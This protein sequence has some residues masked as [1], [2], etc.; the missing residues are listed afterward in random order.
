MKT[1]RKM[2]Q[3]WVMLYAELSQPGSELSDG[4]PLVKFPLRMFMINIIPKDSRSGNTPNNTA[5][6]T[7]F[8]L[9]KTAKLHNPCAIVSMICTK[10]QFKFFILKQLP[11]ALLRI[12]YY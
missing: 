9:W 1:A 11:H 2:I 7:Y 6:H 12:P 4:L 8:F 5:H 3:L 10:N